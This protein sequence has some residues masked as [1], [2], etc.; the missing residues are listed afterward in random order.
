M[1]TNYVLI[2]LGFQFLENEVISDD[3]GIFRNAYALKNKS[4]NKLEIERCVTHWMHANTHT[5]L[6]F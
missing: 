6:A 5:L 3:F 1:E 2:T 4:M